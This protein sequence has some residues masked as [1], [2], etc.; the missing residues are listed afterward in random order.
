MICDLAT[1]FYRASTWSHEILYEQFWDS[2]LLAEIILHGRC[3]E[4]IQQ[5]YIW[6]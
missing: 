5:H 4:G 6:Y 1:P 2:L 3:D